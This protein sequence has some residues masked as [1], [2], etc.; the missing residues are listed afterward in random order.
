[1]YA[2]VLLYFLHSLALLL[3]PRWNP[4]LFREVTVPI[5]LIVQRITARRED[6]ER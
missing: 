4:Q 2:L 3:L 1:M 6:S 5:P